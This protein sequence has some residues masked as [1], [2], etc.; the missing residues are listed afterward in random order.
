MMTSN[1][2][3]TL[4]DFM[5]YMKQTNVPNFT[6]WEAATLAVAVAKSRRQLHLRSSGP[7]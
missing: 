1:M 2:V 3:V 4:L 5:L 7:E 6:L